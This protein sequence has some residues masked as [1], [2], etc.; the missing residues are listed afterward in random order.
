MSCEADFR[1]LFP[2]LVAKNNVGYKDKTESELMLKKTAS[3]LAEAH[4]SGEDDPTNKSSWGLD[5][6]G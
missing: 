2:I 5:E 3:A 4:L 6:C 1:R